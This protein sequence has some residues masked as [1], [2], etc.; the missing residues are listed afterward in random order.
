[1]RSSGSCFPLTPILEASPDWDQLGN[2]AV[3]HLPPQAA[4]QRGPGTFKLKDNTDPGTTPSPTP[5]PVSR[6]RG[7]GNIYVLH[8][9]PRGPLWSQTWPVSTSAP[10]WL[11]L[12]DLYNP[13]ESQFPHL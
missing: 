5:P 10:G 3:L 6:G 9:L 12:G 8:A 7:Q 11:T 1:M 13:S 4:G 2:S